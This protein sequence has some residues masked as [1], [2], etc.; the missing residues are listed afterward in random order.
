MEKKG[1][2]FHKTVLGKSAKPTFKSET[3]FPKMS[4]ESK[5][6]KHGRPLKLNIGLQCE[7]GIPLYSLVLSA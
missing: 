5:K 7:D 6:E 3:A 4:L 1:L 2:H